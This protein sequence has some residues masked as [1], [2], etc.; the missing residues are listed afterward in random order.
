MRIGYDVT[1]AAAVPVPG[2]PSVRFFGGA[3]PKNPDAAVVIQ[4]GHVTL[5]GFSF[6]LQLGD[7]LDV[8]SL[9][10]PSGVHV[11]GDPMPTVPCGDLAASCARVP[12]GDLHL[13]AKSIVAT[14]RE[15][16]SSVTDQWAVDLVGDLRACE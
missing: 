1:F 6:E 4:L 12:L 11:K 2:F 8:R 10:V 5:P 14:W 7:D 15:A 9:R 13:A 3:D 16:L